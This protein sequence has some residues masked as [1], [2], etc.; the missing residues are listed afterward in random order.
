M[1]PRMSTALSAV[2]L[3]AQAAALP[4]ARP[5]PPIDAEWPLVALTRSGDCELAITGNGRFYRIAATGLGANAKGRYTLNNGDMPPIDW[6][7]RANAEGTFA[8]YY[9]PFR[10]H[11]TGG[12]VTVRVSGEACSVAASFPWRRAGVRVQ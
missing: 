9:L 10:W 12:E 3:L 7:I 1:L 6:P 11:R 4:Q 5:V 8:R 2:L